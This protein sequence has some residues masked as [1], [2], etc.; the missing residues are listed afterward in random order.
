MLEGSESFI[1]NV[2]ELHQSISISIIVIVGTILSFSFSLMMMM[3]RGDVD[4]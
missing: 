4:D 1:S 2:V 3:M